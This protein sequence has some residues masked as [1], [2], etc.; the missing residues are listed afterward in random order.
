M[1][2]VEGDG[3]SAEVGPSIAGTCGETSKRST[4]FPV[5][6]KISLPN[7]PKFLSLYHIVSSDSCH[8]MG[9]N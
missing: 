3:R 5:S 2:T 6:V 1:G 8:T 9:K 4:Y 7:P